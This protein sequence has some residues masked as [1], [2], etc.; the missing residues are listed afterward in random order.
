MESPPP[1][2]SVVVPAFDEEAL[3]PAT[4]ATLRGAMPAVPHPGEIVV[5]DNNSRDRTAEVARAAGATVVFEPVN[6]IARARNTGA[7]AARGEWLVFVDADTAVTPALLRDAVDALSS[8]RA[9]GGGTRV[10]FDGPQGRFPRALAAVWD[11]VSKA[12]QLAAGS[13]VFARRDAFDAVGGFPESVYAG[14]EVLLSLRLKKW[15]RARRIPFVVLE[16][17]AVVTSARKLEWFPA[18]RL[19]GTMMLFTV[20]PFLMRSRRFC[21]V[22]YDR[23][24]ASGAAPVTP[25]ASPSPARP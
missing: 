15:G 20:C 19:L 16:G 10:R 11:R 12:F 5:C 18:W 3:L 17:H 21:S 25:P 8:G 9:C 22:W 14:E 24:P 13:F 23:P 2:W 4:L 1:R 7:R 6:Q